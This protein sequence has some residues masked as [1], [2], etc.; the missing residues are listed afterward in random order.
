[1]SLSRRKIHSLT[2]QPIKLSRAYRGPTIPMPFLLHNCLPPYSQLQP[3]LC[4]TQP[5]CYHVCSSNPSFL[6]EPLSPRNVSSTPHTPYYVAVPSRSVIVGVGGLKCGEDRGVSAT[7]Q[8]HHSILCVAMAPWLAIVISEQ[9]SSKQL[10]QL[11]SPVFNQL[12]VAEDVIL[13]VSYVD[14]LKASFCH[15]PIQSLWRCGRTSKLLAPS[16]DYLPL[17]N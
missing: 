10:Y 3:F 9:L 4:R 1:M 12:R 14:V 11:A 2:I 5:L 8:Y 17:V 7:I 15:H 13:D 16:Y 6:H